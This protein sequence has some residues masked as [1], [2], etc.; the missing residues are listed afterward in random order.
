MALLKGET[1]HNEVKSMD[2]ENK[3][4]VLKSLKRKW[5]KKS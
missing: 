2:H 4:T 3:I 1:G 5:G